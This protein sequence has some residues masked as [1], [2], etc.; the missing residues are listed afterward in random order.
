MEKPSYYSITPANVRYDKE[1]KPNEKLLYGEISA[2]SNK[3]GYCTA[4]NGY[5]APLYDAQP[6][7]VSGWISHLKQ[8]GYVRVEVIRD[9]NKMVVQ[10][11]IYIAD[12]MTGRGLPDK[13]KGGYT[14]KIETPPRQKSKENITRDNTTS[15]NN[16]QAEPDKGSTHLSERK[17]IIEYLNH[18]LG[19]NYRVGA[20]KNAERMI[21]RLN[22]GY[23]VDD[24]KKVIDNKY[25]DWAD[26]PKMARYLRPE[27]LFSPKFESYLNERTTSNVQSAPDYQA[28]LNEWNEG[29]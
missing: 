25:T 9:E 16:S 10:R 19:T 2:L 21:A 27:T 18:K 20:K 14:T 6:G 12:S 3:Y 29:N 15:I 5:F 26:S 11:R 8:K 4:S 28:E 23:T 1:L 13:N 22:E 17:E 7:T 24:F